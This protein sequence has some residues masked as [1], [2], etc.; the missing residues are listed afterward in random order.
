MKQMKKLNIL[1]FFVFIHITTYSQQL[2]KEDAVSY[3]LEHNYG[4]TIAKNNIITAENNADILNS[5]YLPSLSANGRAVLQNQSTTTSFQGAI[6]PET[7]LAIAD[8]VIKGANTKNYSAGLDLNYVIFDG[9]ERQYNYKK[10]KENYN[11]TELEARETIENTVVQLF[12]V[13]YQVAQLIESKINLEETLKIS[14]E[15]V[16]R[17]QYRF[18]YGQNNKLDILNAKVD[19][20]N[21][22]INLLNTT[23]QLTTTKR[24]LSLIMNK[25]LEQNFTVDTIVKFTSPLTI[26]S[27]IDKSEKNNVT[28]LQNE[29]N[30]NVS[31]YDIKI[32]KSGYLPS[33]NL[34]GSYG[35]NR[36]LNP[37]AAFFPANTN[38]SNTYQTGLSLSWSIFDGGRTI[39]NVKNAKIAYENQEIQKK[40]TVAIIK[41]DIANAKT[42]YEVK[43]QIFKM[44]KQNVLT[45]LN[46]F[47]RTKE[48]YKL[49]QTT[50]IEFRQAQINL[51]NAQNNKSIAKYD[52]KLAELQLLQLTGQLLNSDF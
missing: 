1:I 13:Y 49:G 30:L 32:A 50:S 51:T 11:V 16:K 48:S 35:W 41:T 23:Q 47:N 21:D 29:A 45:N 7:G 40:N 43:L 9:F 28:L 25:E 18:E 2:S 22:S 6:D 12:S 3:T 33:L 5:G 10:L 15:R 44:Q 52:A 31:A 34:F 20:A 42:N 14:Q 19:V 17:A 39:T 24:D 27:L 46:N 26:Q 38:T 8:N 36:S 37:Q 4:I